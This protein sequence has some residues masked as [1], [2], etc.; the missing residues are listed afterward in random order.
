VHLHGFVVRAFGS[1]EEFLQS[2]DV[3]D[4]EC[5][6]T[7]VRMPGMSGIELQDHLIAQGHQIPVI[8]ITAFPEEPSRIKALAAGAIAFLNKPFDG[9]TLIRCLHEALQA[10]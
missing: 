1:A 6:I 10:A 3:G 4:T 2:P 7:D 5:L 9:A 8:F